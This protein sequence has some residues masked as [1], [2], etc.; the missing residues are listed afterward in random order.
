MLHRELWVKFTHDAK[1]ERGSAVS[2]S[3]F[4]TAVP[5]W[6]QTTLNLTSLSPKRGCGS[7]RVR[8][9]F[10]TNPPEDNKNYINVNLIPKAGLHA[11]PE[12]AVRRANDRG[13]WHSIV[14]NVVIKNVE[15]LPR[16]KKKSSGCSEH[17]AMRLNSAPVVPIG[18]SNI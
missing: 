17:D 11:N 2:F 12:R 10:Y 7:K 16:Q 3:P 14:N 6:E 4:R 8:L 5:F 15:G 13:A 1:L 9:S 18:G